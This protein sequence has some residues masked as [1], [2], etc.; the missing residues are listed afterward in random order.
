MGEKVVF[1][2]TALVHL[3]DKDTRVSL[4]IPES[5]TSQIP[6]SVD[7]AQVK[8]SVVALCETQVRSSYSWKSSKVNSFLENWDVNILW[9]LIQ[10][11][12]NQASKGLVQ[13]Y[14]D[15]PPERFLVTYNKNSTIP[16]IMTDQEVINRIVHPYGVTMQI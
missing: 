13:H 16:I 7:M 3:I 4:T 2:I 14:D 6:V 5:L 12:P 8:E 10:M 9:I 15:R 1:I 11:I